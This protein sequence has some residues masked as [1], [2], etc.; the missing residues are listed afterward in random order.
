[1]KEICVVLGTRPER[2]KLAPLIKLLNSKSE[3]NL[4]VIDTNQHRD[5]GKEV[6]DIFDIK[7]T[8]QC[9]GLEFLETGYKGNQLSAVFNYCYACI[10]SNVLRLKTKPEAI[11]VQGDTTTALA[12]ALVAFHNNIKICHVESGLRTY[13]LRSPYPEEGNRVIIDS[14]SNFCFAPTGQSFE[15]TF[16]SNEYGKTYNVGNTVVDALKYIVEN[17]IDYKET[18]KSENVLITMHRRETQGS[19]LTEIFNVL[20]ELPN[21]ENFTLLKHKNPAVLKSIEESQIEKSKIK[22]VEAKGYLEFIKLLNSAKFVITDSGGIQEECAT[23]RKPCFVLRNKTERMEGVNYGFINLIGTDPK[24]I[25]EKIKNYMETG[26][27]YRKFENVNPFG[28]G[29]SCEKIY[30]ILKAA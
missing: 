21:N 11:V 23:L 10:E 19:N 25:H 17:K 12:G 18:N 4:T 28:D 3:I 8:H 27:W 20:K 22:C 16:V 14:I 26:I 24:T 30:N 29:K 15:T 2:I 5:L 7:P 1:M 6:Y 9:N 13:D